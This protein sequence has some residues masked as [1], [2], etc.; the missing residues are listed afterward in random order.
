[1]KMKR[2]KLVIIGAGQQARNCKRLAKANGYKV[3]AFVDDY[4]KKSV[5]GINVYKYV[6]EI[7]GYQNCY[8][9][10]AIGNNLK[11]RKRYIQFLES[12]HLRFANIIDPRAHIEKGAVIGYGNYIYADAIIYSSAKIGN[13]NI[14]NAKA[15]VATD[16]VVG[17]NCNLMFGSNVCGAVEVGDDSTIGYNASVSSGHNIGKDCFVEANSVVYVDIPD[18][19]EVYGICTSGRGE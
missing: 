4:C 18:K 8:Y 9:I 1:M 2:N 11:A 3:I 16:A 7:K 14:I 12:K 17:N 19:C 6:E 15:L 5:E 13:H 10:V